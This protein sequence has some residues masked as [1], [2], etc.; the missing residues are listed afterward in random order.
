MNVKAQKVL[1]YELSWPDAKKYFSKSDVALVPVGSNEQHGPANPLG[2]DHL[3]AKG[4]AEETARRTGVI[5]LQVVPFGVSPHHK[6][7]WGTHYPYANSLQ[8][9]WCAH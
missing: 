4:I 2:T 7:F 6:Q 8:V 9:A 1:L 5:C 3:I